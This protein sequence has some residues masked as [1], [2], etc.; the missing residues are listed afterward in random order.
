MTC[1]GRVR[2]GRQLKATGS[3]FVAAERGFYANGKRKKVVSVTQNRS[4]DSGDSG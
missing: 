4:I 1:A 2:H 3:D